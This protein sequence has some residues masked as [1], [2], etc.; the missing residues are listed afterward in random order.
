MQG[1]PEK[2]EENILLAGGDL[3]TLIQACPGLLGGENSPSAWHVS[4]VPP[5]IEPYPHPPL[6]RTCAQN[7][8]PATW[9]PGR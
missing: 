9:G 3:M 8:G 4:V 7:A 1:C 6:G 2:L 5:Y